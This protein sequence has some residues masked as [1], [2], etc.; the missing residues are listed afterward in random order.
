QV[1]NRDTTKRLREIGGHD[2]AEARR[3]LQS[4][5]AARL[6][7]RTF[8]SIAVHRGGWNGPA[9][10]IDKKRVRALLGVLA[11]HA[12]E[13]LTRDGAID[14]LWPDA[15]GDAAVNSLNQTVYQLRR[16]LDPSY[17]GGDS[18][19][20]VIST[21][22]HVAL[23]HELVHTDLNELGRL[24]HRLED[25]T[26]SD[27]HA[28]AGRLLDLVGGEFLGDLRYEDWVSRTQLA[29][30]TEVRALLLPIAQ[31]TRGQFDPN[32]STR[33]ASVLLR[34]DPYDEAAILALAS[35]MAA[36]GQR[37]AA[38]AVVFDHAQ[39]VR[40]EFDDEPSAE[41]VAA[42]EAIAPGWHVKLR[43]TQPASRP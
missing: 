23:N 37:I 16:H 39:R 2:V 41:F 26:W 22:D 38:R 24:A 30:H 29:V 1:A 18:A 40:R 19:E 36:S 32:T 34:F 12:R 35:G 15:D 28:L 43:L 6:Y 31:S 8:G 5:Q 20:Y 17:R 10:T 33:A 14:L 25:G 11:A 9:I 13:P 21:S 4:A 27:R 3:R 42:A 7:V